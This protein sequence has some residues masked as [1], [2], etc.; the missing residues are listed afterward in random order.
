MR[1]TYGIKE[2]FNSTVKFGIGGI[3]NVLIVT[4]IK[5]VL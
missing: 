4:I 5:T 2:I 3:T 1:D